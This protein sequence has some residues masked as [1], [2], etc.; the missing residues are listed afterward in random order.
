MSGK[1]KVELVFREPV[2]REQSGVVPYAESSPLEGYMSKGLS[3]ESL[4]DKLLNL[5]NFVVDEIEISLE[6]I[7]ET[8]ALTQL[9]VS[10]TGTGGVTITLKPKNKN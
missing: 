6:T 10:A 5:G 9:F 7:V 2:K 1:K 4:Q 3:I 8:G